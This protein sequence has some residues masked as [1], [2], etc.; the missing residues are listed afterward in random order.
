VSRADRTRLPVPGAAPAFRFPPI[1]R[2]ALPNGLALWTVEEPSLPVV[3]FVLLLPFGSAADPDGR[4][5]LAALIGDM[6]DEG[7]GHRSA[8]DIS[9]EIAGMGARVD[10]EVTADA[11]LVSVTVLSEYSA[12]ALQLLADCAARPALR[13]EDFERVRR[14]RASRLV[15]LRDV[16]SAVADWAFMRLLYGA[17][18]YGHLA[19]GATAS[20]LR[21]S[22]DDVVTFHR[23]AFVPSGATLVAAGAV[24]FAGLRRMAGEAFGSWIP[25]GDSA[26][27]APALGAAGQAPVTEAAR[28]RLALVSKPGAAQSELRM[29]YVALP[30][31]SPDYHAVLVLNAV[32]GG[33]FV[34]RINLKLRQEKG[35][36]YGART[37]FDFRRGRGPFLLQ[38][39]VQT[40]V[41]VEAIREAL[42]ELRA[43]RGDRPPTAQELDMAKASLTRGYARNFETPEQLARAMVQLVLY[44]LP[45]DYFDRFVPAVEAIDARDVRAAAVE[46]LDPDRMAT[47]LVC[48]I[49]A[50]GPRLSGGECGEPM[51]MAVEL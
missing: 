19:V 45:G 21:M 4:H 51:V 38:A 32:L 15:Q 26:P 23:E 41:T 39:A 47:V 13:A 29:G 10:T 2:D 34:S 22:S 31:D 12:R 49:E 6:L 7:S 40:G 48:D 44:G 50:V 33:Q 8:L 30:R 28:R 14:L 27:G 3:T 36:T 24:D 46:H 18:P 9:A 43:I 20:L 11:T 37:V 5:G 35:Y 1:A 16:P 42:A 17:H 25:S